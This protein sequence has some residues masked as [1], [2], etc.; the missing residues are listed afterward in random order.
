MSFSTIWKALTGIPVWL[1]L[2]MGAILASAALWI[3]VLTNRVQSAQ[4]KVTALSELLM[5]SEAEVATQ[6]KLRSADAIA[7]EARGAEIIIIN[8]EEAASSAKLDKAIKAN[9]DWAN[10]PVPSDIADGLQP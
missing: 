1:W 5:A 4:T 3:T 9:P 2:G 6:R 8:R 10:Q 7:A